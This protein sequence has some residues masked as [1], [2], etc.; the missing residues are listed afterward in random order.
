M[1]H[2]R[3]PHGRRHDQIGDALIARFDDLGRAHKQFAVV[4]LVDCAPDG[5]LDRRAEVV[6]VEGIEAAVHEAEA[7]GRAD[8]G[9]AGDLEDSAPMNGEPV[10]VAAKLLPRPDEG[11]FHGGQDNV[12]GSSWQQVPTGFN[13]IRR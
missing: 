10:D 7:V 8:H 13:W 2:H 6:Q 5:H 1:Q 4:V 11:V 3:H 12:H 9:I